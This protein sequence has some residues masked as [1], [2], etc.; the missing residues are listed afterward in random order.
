[1]SEE[2]KM[3]RIF[4]LPFQQESNDI[5]KKYLPD[6]LG[7]DAFKAEMLALIDKYTL[8][9]DNIHEP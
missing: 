2:Q 8:D 1:M 4:L 9:I 3:V 7:S 5:M 6:K